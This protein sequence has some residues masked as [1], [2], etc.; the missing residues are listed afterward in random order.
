MKVIVFGGD[1]FCGWPTSLHLAACG[2]EVVI[3]DNL[4]RR[5]IDNELSSGSLTSIASIADRVSAA[6]ELV[7]DITFEFLDI[8]TDATALR[9]LVRKT[10][11]DA[12]IQF[13]EQRAAPYSMIDDMA[14][15]YTV[16]NNIVGTHNICSALVDLAPRAHLLHLGTMGVYGYSKAFGKIPEGYLNVR[17][18][19][20]N[21]DVD[22]LYP[23]NPGSIYHMSKCL[24]QVIFQFYA[25]NWGLRITDLHQGIVWGVHTEQTL[26]DNRLINRL[27]YDGIYGTVV[28][29]ASG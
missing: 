29:N 27:D 17:I 8:A 4:S 14:R 19:E 12:V 24:D 3:V 10:Q 26:K 1:G 21:Q 28:F 23:G 11:P 13:A 2:H 25:K 22:I 16:D 20:T 7:G 18:N 15:R 5:K 9:E 6:R